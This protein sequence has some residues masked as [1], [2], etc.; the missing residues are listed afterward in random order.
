MA[1]SFVSFLLALLSK[2]NAITF[3]AIIPF[4][5]YIFNKGKINQIVFSILPPIIASILFLYIRHRVLGDTLSTP[6]LELM[7]NPFV[8]ATISQKYATIFYTLGIYIKLLFWPHP[9]TFDYYPYHIEIVNWSNPLAFCSGVVYLSLF[10][11]MIWAIIKKQFHGFS[12]LIYLASLSIVSNLFFPIGTFM[13]ERFIFISSIGFVVF[14][15]FLVTKT[16]PLFIKNEKK[17]ML[18]LSVLLGPIL[19]LSSYK[20]I[21][22]NKAWKDDF[23]LF[24]TDVK[25]SGNSAK[26]TCS[27]GGKLYES[28]LLIK[29]SVEKFKVLDQSVFYLQKA[30]IIHPTYNDA[31]L[32]LGNALY[33]YKMYDSMLVCYKRIV[34]TAPYFQKVYENLPL[35]VNKFK[36]SDK[37]ILE[38]EYFLNINKFDYDLM[39]QLGSIYGRE[40]SDYPKLFII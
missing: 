26:S 32:L 10:C 16:L 40:K 15:A 3:L 18:V 19:L 39:Y 20:I 11:Y 25:V 34:A 12:A 9:L 2:E 1:V 13:N 27:A 36:D 14:I 23:T 35:V 38:Y 29:D 21:D 8:H 6:I 17:Y 28:A 22:R 30:V 4:S 37:K 7:N 33:E 5:L 31:L 24:T